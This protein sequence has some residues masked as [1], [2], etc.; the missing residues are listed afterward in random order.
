MCRMSG[1]VTVTMTAGITVTN[2]SPVPHPI[3]LVE[4]TFLNVEMGDA[5]RVHG[6]VMETRTA[7]TGKM[8][9]SPASHPQKVRVI[10]HTFVVDLGNVSLGA[11]DVITMMI[12]VMG[13]MR[14]TAWKVNLEFALKRKEHVIVESAFIL[15]NGAMASQIA[16]IRRM[17]CSVISTVQRK[18]SDVNF[19]LIAFSRIGNVMGRETAV[20]GVTRKIVL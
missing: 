15:G 20:M 2:L 18:N 8:N 10:R 13:L 14:K 3:E 17:R 12:A 5:S 16:R 7:R 11:G 9:Q 6:S 1:F 4:Q 19:H